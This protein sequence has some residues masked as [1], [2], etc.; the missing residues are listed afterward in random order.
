MLFAHAETQ[1]AVNASNA[2]IKDMI[3]TQLAVYLLKWS[4]LLCILKAFL[5]LEEHEC[6][7]GL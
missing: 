3:E 5:V 6:Y 2:R 1:G 4:L 7:S